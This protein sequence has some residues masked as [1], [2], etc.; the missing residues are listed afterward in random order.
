[1]PLPGIFFAIAQDTMSQ[2]YNAIRYFFSKVNLACAVLGAMLLFLVTVSIC[3]EV[4]TRA[5]GGASRLWVIEVSEYTLLFIAFLGAP[6]LLEKNK[7]VSLD[8]FYNSLRGRSRRLVQSVNALVGI[9]ACA[10]LG[11]VG[12]HVVIDQLTIGVR[13]VTVM[14]PLSWWITAAVPVGM[15]LMTVQFLDQLVSILRG[16]RD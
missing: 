7:H 4:F 15:I 12:V 1:M 10:T 16:E 11:I 6:Y 13:E 2:T 5:L 3:L 8:L 9:G 14:R